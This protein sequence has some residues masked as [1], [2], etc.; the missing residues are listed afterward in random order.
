MTGGV[1]FDCDGVLVDTEVVANTVL[2]GLVTDLG[3]PTTTEESI[4]RYMGL[5][6]ASIV[7]TIRSEIGSEPPA[8]LHG[9]YLSGVHEAWRRELRPIPGIVEVLDRLALPFCVASSGEHERVRLTLGLTGLLPRF[10]GKIFSATDVARGKPAPDLFLHAA[11]SMGFDPDTTTVVEDTVPGVRAALA[12]GMR[13]LAYARLIDA[14]DLEAAGGEVF[15]DM[16]D[17]PGL[18]DAN[19]G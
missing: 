9:R 12:A 6:W 5:S 10:E 16:A 18:L 7:D 1:I 13:A 4:R 8:D 2:A 17:L 14:R 11:R 15:T 3:F 19:Q